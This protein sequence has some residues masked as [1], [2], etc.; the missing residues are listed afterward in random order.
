MD[1]RIVKADY[2]NVTHGEQIVELLSEYA[3][4]A[5][6]GGEALSDYTKQNLIRNLQALPHA[7]SILAYVNDQPAGLVNCFEAFST[8]TCRPLINVHDVMVL[9]NYRGLGLS[10]NMLN[11]VEAIAKEKRCGKLTLEVL[12]GNDTAKQSYSKFG[13]EPYEL[14]QKMGKAEFW[15]KYIV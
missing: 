5:M 6:G 4:D 13:F 14:D 15:Q 11:Q 10:H 2:N 9:A 3:L 1:I 7:F 12:S 8:F